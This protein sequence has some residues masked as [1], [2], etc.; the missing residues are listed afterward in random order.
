MPIERYHVKITCA[1][2]SELVM[3]GV[4]TSVSSDA[5]IVY[6]P[7]GEL[8]SY[9]YSGVTTWTVEN[10][11]DSTISYD[12]RKGDAA[13]LEGFRFNAF[14][15]SPREVTIKEHQNKPEKRALATSVEFVKELADASQ[16]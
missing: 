1:D 9:E 16:T 11:D 15:G 10:H 8:P 14:F 7:Y 12:V 5:G 2:K 13:N 4:V 3:S 6:V